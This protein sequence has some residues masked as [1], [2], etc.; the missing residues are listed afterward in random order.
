MIEFTNVSKS[1][2]D[3]LILRDINMTFS[4]GE[5]VAIIG[6]SGCGKTTLLK[7][8]A[9]AMAPDGGSLNYF[10][11]EPLKD[12]TVFRRSCGY[13]PQENPLMDELSVLYNMRLWGYDRRNPDRA[14]L[15]QFELEKLLKTKVSKLSGGMKRRVSLACGV[16]SHPGFLIMDEPTAALD[17]CY[18][19]ELLQW[20]KKYQGNSGIVLMTTHEEAEIMEADKCYVMRA[21]TLFK[22]D[23]GQRNMKTILDYTKES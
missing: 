18:R 19:D 23:D 6:S 21:G 12:K 2:K 14:L 7:I 8:L 1:Y 3:K 5:F 20:L 9:G 15:E 13:V 11:E 22:I 10:G 4:S 17:I 16:I